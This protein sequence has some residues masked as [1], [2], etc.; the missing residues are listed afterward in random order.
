MIRFSKILS[1]RLTFKCLMACSVTSSSFLFH[2][3]QLITLV[4][5]MPIMACSD[6]P[7]FFI[8]SRVKAMIWGAT[9]PGYRPFPSLWVELQQEEAHLFLRVSTRHHFLELLLQLLACADGL[10]V[11]G[12]VGQLLQPGVGEVL[13]KMLTA[14]FVGRKEFLKEKR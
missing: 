8:S 6:R 12:E 2:S 7:A 4:Q 3:T 13:R 5:M 9:P 14:P 11:A 10:L 1:L